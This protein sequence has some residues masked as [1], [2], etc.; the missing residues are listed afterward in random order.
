MQSDTRQSKP[1]F[2]TTNHKKTDGGFVS[3]PTDISNTN[4]LG[5]RIGLRSSLVDLSASLCIRI[6][7]YWALCE[8][9]LPLTNGFSSQMPVGLTFD[10]FLMLV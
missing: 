5:L 6:P 3:Y 9:N 7:H 2:R 10:V 8:R 1:I 4:M